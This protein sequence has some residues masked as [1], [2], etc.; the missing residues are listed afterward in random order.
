MT[1]KERVLTVLGNQGLK[2]VP[3]DCEANAGIDRGGKEHFGL[4]RGASEG[5]PQELGAG[6]RGVGAP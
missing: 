6:F 3:V 1:S 2:C 4:E 5:L